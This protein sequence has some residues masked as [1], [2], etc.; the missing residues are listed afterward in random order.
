MIPNV[1]AVPA[2]TF[3]YLIISLASIWK[4]DEA[5]EFLTGKIDKPSPGRLV[6]LMGW[7]LLLLPLVLFGSLWI[8]SRL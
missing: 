6:K 3:I 8:L 2:A 4:G 1:I 5:G 7:V